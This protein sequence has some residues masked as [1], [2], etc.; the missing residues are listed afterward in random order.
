MLTYVA[1]SM[2]GA[3]FDYK[4]AAII[5]VPTT[6]LIYLVPFILPNDPAGHK[7]AH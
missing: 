5:S 7:E 6:I 2:I 1:T 4:V 3:E